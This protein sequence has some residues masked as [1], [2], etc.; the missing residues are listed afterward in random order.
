MVGSTHGV[1][2]SHRVHKSQPYGSRVHMSHRVPKS[3]RAHNS[4]IEIPVA[5]LARVA[6]FGP[7]F[8]VAMALTLGLDSESDPE[9]VTLARQPPTIVTPTHIASVPVPQ[10]TPVPTVPT[11]TG[12]APT[13][14]DTGT[15]AAAEA[16][17]A[18][19]LCEEI[20]DPLKIPISE[21]LKWTRTQCDLH[22]L[23]IDCVNEKRPKKNQ[24]GPN[25][26][27]DADCS[28]KQAVNSGVEGAKERWSAR[29][30]A[31]DL[32]AYR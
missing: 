19:L 10:S 12:N 9:V 32:T 8:S 13:I 28:Q 24:L 4:H 15:P 31:E 1:H 5:I 25:C 20:K 7:V 23:C 22:M 29:R 3:Q 16:P 6:Q 17:A 18:D 27:R 11:P 2:M 14:A 30:E 21:R 26:K